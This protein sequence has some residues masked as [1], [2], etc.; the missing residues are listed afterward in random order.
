[1]P[2]SQ[3]G[4]VA[5]FSAGLRLYRGR[6]AGNRQTEAQTARLRNLPHRALAHVRPRPDYSK[7]QQ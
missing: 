1:M 2:A 4:T 7:S 3:A 6:P 5:D